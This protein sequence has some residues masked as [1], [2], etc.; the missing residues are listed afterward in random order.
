MSIDN[1]KILYIEDDPE[2]RSLMADIIRYKGYQFYE[3]ARGLD[4][5]QMAIEHKPDLILVDLRL[6]DMQGYEVTTHLKSLSDIKNTPIIALTG[7]MH[8]DARDLTLA[9]GCDGYI[10]K[11]INVTEFLFKIEEYLSG[12]KD[13]ISP[14][15]EK[16]FLQKYNVQL[17]EKLRRKLLELESLNENLTKL[18]KELYE[19]HQDLAK[20]NDRLF[21]LNNVANFLR[22][23]RD[24]ATLLKILPE[25]IIEGF[26][27]ERC[28]SFELDT[29]KRKLIPFSFDGVTSSSIHKKS[30]KYKPEFLTYL[31]K[32]GG[33]IWIKNLSEILEPSLL[34]L[35][36]N[37]RTESFILGNL[38][39][40]A[41]KKDS[42]EIFAN[43]ASNVTSDEKLELQMPK[44]YLIF[45][46]KGKTQQDF[47][48]YEVRILKS[49][50][51]TIGIIYEN[52]ILY[53]KLMKLYKI[54]E[55]QAITD[56]LTKIYNYRYFIQQLERE[57]NRGKRFKTPFSLLI[58]DIDH[59]KD[60]NDRHGHPE[61]DKI[62]CQVSLILSE[63]T[64]SLDTV[65]RYGGE[66]FV[67]I[68]PGLDKQNAIWI[69]QKLH[70]LIEDFEFNLQ[71]FQP[72][73]K[74]TV[75]IGL[76]NFPDD[77][78]DMEDLIERAD[79]ALYK[80]KKS[81]RNRVCIA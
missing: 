51:Q 14:E 43:I 33:I 61:G 66:E 70:N 40:L 63:N 37:L 67:I 5:I 3:A 25:K 9:A 56:G 36:K 79:Q 19:S 31:K 7:E 12:K 38:S 49:F 2:T 23:Q 71:Q 68:L 39:N 57:M 75:S 48:T 73:G 62:L 28:I 35:A 41:V 27:V 4:G 60:Y 65:A 78:T 74:L 72:L 42:T 80:A 10:S 24:P 20:Y 76:A 21:Y 45:I 77:G 69:A 53:H 58:I 22:T 18:N 11:P 16:K 29:I 46:D 26:K 15:K 47:E 17:V 34:S 44:R 52:M 55:Q 54:K 8:R 59:F 64:R 81:G 13:F 6:P 1:K 50:I 30:F 32:D